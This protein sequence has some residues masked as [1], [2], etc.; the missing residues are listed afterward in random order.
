LIFINQALHILLY[1]S[2]DWYDWTFEFVQVQLFDEDKNI[3][4]N[5]QIHILWGVKVK[6][7]GGKMK[8]DT[9]TK[10]IAQCKSCTPTTLTPQL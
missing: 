1:N 2:N 7:Q 10:P 9:M 4:L 3:S 6:I 8:D 5:I